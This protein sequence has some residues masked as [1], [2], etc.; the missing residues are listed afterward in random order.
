MTQ[1]RSVAPID[2]ATRELWIEL[3]A[4]LW[5]T[6][7]QCGQPDAAR[8]LKELGVRRGAGTVMR[9]LADEYMQA[10]RMAAL[11]GVA[12]RGQ[13]VARRRLELTLRDGLDHDFH[14]LAATYQQ[15][16]LTLAPATGSQLHHWLEG[17]SRVH[18]AQ[19]EGLARASHHKPLSTGR[20]RGPPTAATMQPAHGCLNTASPSEPV[21]ERHQ[22]TNHE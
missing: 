15:L 18:A 22:R 17:R 19:A 14:R 12:L 3:M 8:R 11:C 4:R 20:A 7:Q 21:L 13:D 16:L 5:R 1:A 10:T 6:L 9:H 2:A